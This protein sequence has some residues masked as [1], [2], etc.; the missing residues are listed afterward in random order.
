MLIYV[1]KTYNKALNLTS[2]QQIFKL[3]KS[4]TFYT[5]HYN[6]QYKYILR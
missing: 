3:Y 2:E 1:Q 5:E 4:K 6:F